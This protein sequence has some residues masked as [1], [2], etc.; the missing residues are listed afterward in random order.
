ML[1]LNMENNAPAKLNKYENK[2]NK[3]RCCYLALQVLYIK[4]KPVN[5]FQQLISMQSAMNN[6]KRYTTF[7]NKL[8]HVIV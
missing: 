8:T 4:L 1:N 3:K 7:C 5:N 2:K 6:V